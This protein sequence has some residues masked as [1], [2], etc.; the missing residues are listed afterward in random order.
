MS[1]EPRTADIEQPPPMPDQAALDAHSRRGF[2]FPY[3]G[4]GLGALVA[5][6]AAAW[7]RSRW[8]EA[9]L[10]ER[11][12]ERLRPRAPRHEAPSAADIRVD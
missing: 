1:S 7:L 11:T 10:D 3:L 12:R 9:P 4:V 8:R 2:A 5:L 6:G